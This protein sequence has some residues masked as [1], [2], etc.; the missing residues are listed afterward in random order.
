MCALPFLAYYCF[1]K[2]HIFV[3][4]LSHSLCNNRWIF[5]QF[6]FLHCRSKEHASHKSPNLPG[7]VVGG[8]CPRLNYHSSS[9]QIGGHPKNNRYG[10]QADGYLWLSILL[11]KRKIYICTAH[12]R[13]HAPQLVFLVTEGIIA[14]I[15]RQAK[16]KSYCICIYK[17]NINCL[18]TFC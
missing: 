16:H 18:P 17:Y 3:I 11:K 9:S 10:S 1:I 14:D 8:H 5:W 6:I 4:L 7:A 13:G 2:L 15:S 12:Y